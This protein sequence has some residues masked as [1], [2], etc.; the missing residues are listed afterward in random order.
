ME[1]STIYRLAEVVLSEPAAC[2]SASIALGVIEHLTLD[3]TLRAHVSEE[4][5]TILTEM[6][7]ARASLHQFKGYERKELVAHHI[8]VLTTIVGLYDEHGKAFDWLVAHFDSLTP[9]FREQWTMEEL[10][11][12]TKRRW[13]LVRNIR[14]SLSAGGMLVP[15]NW[16]EDLQNTFVMVAMAVMG[17][18]RYETLR[19][20]VRAVV[21]MVAQLKMMPAPAPQ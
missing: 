14:N 7:A 13:E 5:F 4:E 8:E 21:V 6:C 2:S 17:P 3:E 16:F 19:T 10:L 20:D 12:T 1:Q 18:E 11:L 9:W 15:E